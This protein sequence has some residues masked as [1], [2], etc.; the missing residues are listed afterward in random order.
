[1]GGWEFMGLV[2]GFIGVASR[3]LSVNYAF[4]YIWNGL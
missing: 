3:F 2:F 1:M 4:V